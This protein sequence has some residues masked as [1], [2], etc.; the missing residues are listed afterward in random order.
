[1]NYCRGA[2]G[3]WPRRRDNW[4]QVCPMRVVST[5]AL[6]GLM[7]RSKMAT[8]STVFCHQRNRDR[9]Q[10]KRQQRIKRTK[11]CLTRGPEPRKELESVKSNHSS[12]KSAIV[13][14]MN[15]NSVP[16]QRHELDGT[17][18]H[19]GGKQSRRLGNQISETE[20]RGPRMGGR[21]AQ[22]TSVACANGARQ[23]HKD[24]RQTLTNYHHIILAGR[25]RGPSSRNT[26]AAKVKKYRESIFLFY[27]LF[28]ATLSQT[29]W[30]KLKLTN[31]RAY[32]LRR[33]LVE[34]SLVKVSS[35]AASCGLKKLA[36]GICE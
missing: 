20:L 14:K 4:R 5:G 21:C 33:R 13:Y 29:H 18:G 19:V 32:G 3:R 1:M 35:A 8:S 34:P 12:V 36:D 15:P 11:G 28:V 9:V 27:F 22:A 31:R 16:K 25:R 6:N 30:I 17:K 7:A 26:A 2:N 23:M 10:G 24:V